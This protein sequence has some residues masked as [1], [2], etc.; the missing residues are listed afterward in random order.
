M[1]T[2]TDNSGA[3]IPGAT[4]TVTS[5]ATGIEKKA[6]TNASGAYSI[7]YLP[8][9]APTTSRSRPTASDVEEEKGIVLQIN[10]QAKMNVSMHVGGVSQVVEV[11][12]APSRCS[13]L[14]T[15]RLAWSSAPKPQ[16]TFRSMGANLTILPFSRRASPSPIRT[17]TPPARAAQA[18]TR[19]ANQTWGQ[20]NVDGITMVSNRH[21]Y[22]NLYPSVDAVAEFK[23]FTG[24]AEAEYGGDAGAVINIQPKN[25]R[26]RFSRRPLRVRS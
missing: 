8:S 24:N 3:V 26:Q 18:S 23:V 21:A 2:I 16:V 5:V 6:V 1:G 12:A 13:R 22:V 10:Q 25:R 19:M 20:T 7:T 15:P 11:E 4:V 14:R 17:I 9:Q